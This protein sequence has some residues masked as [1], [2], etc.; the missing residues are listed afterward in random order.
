MLTISTTN[1][2]LYVKMPEI[3]IDGITIDTLNLKC[4]INLDLNLVFFF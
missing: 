4:E 1:G 2:C 3:K